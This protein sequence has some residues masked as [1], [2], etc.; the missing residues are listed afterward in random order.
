MPREIVEIVAEKYVRSSGEMRS[1]VC[2]SIVIGSQVQS[3]TQSTLIAPMC[4]YDFKNP[5]PILQVVIT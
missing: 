5:I 4:S 3:R 1:H 2:A